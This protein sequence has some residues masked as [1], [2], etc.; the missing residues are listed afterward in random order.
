L[1]VPAGD[2]VV[3]LKL[4]GYADASTPVTVAEG[5]TATVDLTLTT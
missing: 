5:E 2:H 4:D 3:T 1:R